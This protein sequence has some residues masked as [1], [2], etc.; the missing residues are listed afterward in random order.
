MKHQV[1]SRTSGRLALFLASVAA[2]VA[3]AAIPVGD[4]NVQIGGFFSQGWLY[5]SDN[6]FPTADKGGTWD[7]REMAFNAST[8]VGS[9]LRVGAQV[10]AQR[11]GNLG[12]D[13]VI[14]DWA[15]AD[16]NFNPAFGIRAGRVKYPKGLYGEALDLDV[17]RPFIFL[18]TAVYNPILRDFSA[19]F[20]G[21]MVYGSLNAGKGSFDYKVF[22]GKI[23]MSP[24][25][26]VAEFY[27][28][29]GFYT[30]AGVGGLNMK[31]VD[32]AQLA[33]NTPISGLKFVYSYSEFTDLSSDGPFAAYAPVNFH[34]N[35]HSFTWNTAS[36]EYTTGNWVF[37]S[38][39]QRSNGGLSYS[40][41]P[42]VPVTNSAVG[43]DG[44]Y[45]S[46]ARRLND[47]F[48]VGTYYG[49]LETRE[50]YTGKPSDYQH[51]YALSLRYD[52]NEHL[53]F[54]IEGHYID[55]TYQTF[56]TTRIP[57]P[58]ATRANNTTIFAVKTTLSF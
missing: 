10:F 56:D 53:L 4:S 49:N 13:R 24:S 30:A 27:N 19:S 3:H 11:L 43:W 18:P 50:G 17:V 55:G 6:N 45:V 34:S 57:N 38:E 32:G 47:K 25:Q 44:W 31:S 12:E 22:A 14:L 21:A 23:P 42:F 58:A 46:A 54:K 2:V 39:W 28:N 20:D 29:A 35:I 41:A 9:H 16:Y 1:T 8:T 7:F 48:E 5:S 36:A 26:G 52:Y 40:A 37:A 51:D 15:V 33:W